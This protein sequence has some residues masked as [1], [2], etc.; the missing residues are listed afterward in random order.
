MGVQKHYKKR[1]TKKNVS[2]SFYFLQNNRQKIQNRFFVGF[3]YHVFGLFSV[4]GVQKHQ[5][6]NIGKKPDP[7][8][9]LASPGPF[10]GRRRFSFESDVY[11]ADGHYMG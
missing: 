2:K 10:K 3:V 1:F 11:L 8:P 6:E 4:R 5:K 9:F 7:G